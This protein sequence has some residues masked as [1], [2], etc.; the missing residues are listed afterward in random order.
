MLRS[1]I[2]FV[3][4]RRLSD[5]LQKRCV[6]VC[7]CEKKKLFFSA[8]LLTEKKII[9]HSLEIVVSIITLRTKRGRRGEEKSERNREKSP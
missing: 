9:K 4:I 2:H 3:L 8:Q 7:V 1:W 5:Q 6:C